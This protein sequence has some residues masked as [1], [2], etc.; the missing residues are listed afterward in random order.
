[1]AIWIILLSLLLCFLGVYIHFWRKLN[2]FQ[3]KGVPH[4]KPWPFL[5]NMSPIIFQK[6]TLPQLISTTYNLYSEAK[7]IGFYEFTNTIIILRDPEIIK[8]IGI[9]NFDNFSNRR[10]FADE[11]QDP[12]FGKEMFSLKG[13]KWHEIR[14]LLSPSFTS[15]KMKIMFKL[16]SQQ[17]KG[18]CDHILKEGNIELEIK[19][20]FQ[21][22]TADI[23]A[24]C[25][26]GISTNCVKDSKNELYV[27]GLR[28]VNIENV[29]RKKEF[30]LH[31]PFLWKL[32]GMSFFDHQVVKLFRNIVETTVSQRKEKQIIRPDMLQL[33]MDAGDKNNSKSDKKRELSFEE[34]TAHAFIFF[35]GSFHTTSSTLTFL[36]YEMAIHPDIQQKLQEEIDSVLNEE[37]TNKNLVND[38]PS[39]EEINKLKFL[40]AVIKENMRLH[41]VAP[42]LERTCSNNFDLPPSLPD[43]KPFT[44]KPGMI[45][46]I[47]IEGIHHDP[48]YYENPGKFDPDRFLKEDEKFVL[49]SPTFL[50]FGIGPRGC[51]AYRFALLIFKVVIFH[52]FAKC[53]VKVCSKTPI[54]LVMRKKTLTNVSK[55]EI[56]LEVEER[57]SR[58]RL[59]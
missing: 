41:A 16:I 37:L 43:S 24:N 10:G 50:P 55:R 31:F 1:M 56:L 29:T 15:R 28:A 8:S 13:E 18:F 4:S 52:F 45:L 11:D 44:L 34:M 20:S 49:N 21:K 35:F 9:T 39:Y 48:D 27:L 25:A 54:P 47:P 23:I 38:Q 3:R 2:I 40:D 5:G 17:A 30:L 32:F 46:W 22:L 53:N 19:K 26:Y 7:Y 59:V 57:K 33:M 51:I 12:L 42:I 36:T 6:M 58:K 14:S